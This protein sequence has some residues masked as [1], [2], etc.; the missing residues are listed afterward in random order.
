[1]TTFDSPATNPNPGRTNAVA[2]EDGS[3]TIYQPNG[4][5]ISYYSGSPTWRNSNPG[6]LNAANPPRDGEIGVDG[7]G[8]AIFEDDQAGRDALERALREEGTAISKNLEDLIPSIANQNG[9]P[10]NQPLMDAIIAAGGNGAYPLLSGQQPSGIIDTIINLFGQATHFDQTGEQTDQICPGGSDSLDE[11]GDER[12]EMKSA[13]NQQG[14]SLGQTIDSYAQQK[15]F[16]SAGAQSAVNSAGV[17]P[18]TITDN[19]SAG[20][21]DTILDTLENFIP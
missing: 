11:G 8:K 10:N 15:G 1:M 21:W 20:Q 19:I 2:N 17:S 16:D 4:C 13:L 9:M 6:N 7:S 3:V 18:N 5:Y 14:Q 12:E